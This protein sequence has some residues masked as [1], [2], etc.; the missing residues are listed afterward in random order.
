[1]CQQDFR[2]QHSQLTPG[3]YD[4]VDDDRT[5]YNI[6]VSYTHQLP[7]LAK[8]ARSTGSRS[9]STSSASSSDSGS[10]SP[11]MMVSAFRKSHSR[12]S[13]ASSNYS[14]ASL[15]FGQVPFPSIQCSFPDYVRHE[16][17]IPCSSSSSSSRPFLPSHNA[18][19]SSTS[20]ILSITSAGSGMATPNSTY[21]LT[22]SSSSMIHAFPPIR[23]NLE[24]HHHLHHTHHHH[25]HHHHY[26]DNTHVHPPNSGNGNNNT[27]TRV[28][29]ARN[30]DD[31]AKHAFPAH[32]TTQKFHHK[33]ENDTVTPANPRPKKRV[34]QS[35]NYFTNISNMICL[36]WFNDYSVL[37][38]AY[39]RAETVNF[40]ANADTSVFSSFS[41]SK[42]TTPTKA[43]NQ[44]IMSV[45]K[46]TQ[47]PP[48]AVS[49]ALYYI[50]RLKKLSSKPIVGNA[51]SEYRVFS[52]ALM[53]ANKFLD[54]NTYTN[55]TWAEVTHL[56]LKEISAMEV[57]FLANLRYSLYVNADD[58]AAWQRR[59]RVW[60]HLHSCIC[61]PSPSLPSP[62][63]TPS[64][65]PTLPALA[66]YSLN[67]Q[68]TS[69]NTI[70]RF[71][72]EHIDR[73]PPKKLALAALTPSPALSPSQHGRIIATN[74]LSSSPYAPGF[75]VRAL[76]ANAQV[77]SFSSHGGYSSA[78]SSTMSS[79]QNPTQPLPP[80]GH[81]HLPPLQPAPH[82]PVY[83]Y[84]IADQKNKVNPSPQYG[85][86]P[87][88]S[89]TQSPA[90]QFDLE[91]FR[92][93]SASFDRPPS[94]HM[95]PL[96]LGQSTQAMAPISSIPSMT[97]M[98]PIQTL[99][100]TA[101]P[102]I[103]SS[104]PSFPQHPHPPP[105][106]G[107]EQY[108]HQPQSLA[109][110]PLPTSTLHSTWKPPQQLYTNPPSGSTTF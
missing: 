35:T 61:I 76:L 42:L 45:I 66:S 96:H 79:P 92:P 2:Q 101:M 1:M 73:P 12:N 34:R 33:E 4:D 99:P 38:A 72:A 57:E 103:Q 10:R 29:M 98:P 39:E 8:T 11:A 93:K 64:S 20:S 83:Y 95:P 88:G 105:A 86:L 84:S 107:L 77:P 104:A 102:P 65:G 108:Q 60:L 62:A 87:P 49:L 37:E 82:Q 78:S 50:L 7:Q 31:T 69:P 90:C 53:L 40:S 14:N 26:H 27:L 109:A 68:A 36:F 18:H 24:S 54:D 41:F 43:F 21:S 23:H 74:R 67:S 97:A 47:L 32:T 46:H 71:M 75:P 94:S 22:P 63:F 80:L 30:E 19:H 3:Y 56:P 5:Q 48:T 17:P 91:H 28:P 52:I 110:H 16:D 15:N 58:W 9:N 106:H 6:N 51:N 70:K 13:S 81:P 85:F 55:K 44:F 25:H 100:M 89:Q 59:L